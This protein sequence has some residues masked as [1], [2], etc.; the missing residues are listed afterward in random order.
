MTKK[1]RKEC[2]RDLLFYLNH[3]KSLEPR[4]QCLDKEIQDLIEKLEE[5]S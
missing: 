2:E 3:Y 1:E 4:F 5:E